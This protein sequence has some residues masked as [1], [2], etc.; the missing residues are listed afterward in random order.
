MIELSFEKNDN[1]M[2]V[3]VFEP[4]FTNL[5]FASFRE[6]FEQKFSESLFFAIDLTAVDY[7]DSAGIGSIITVNNNLEDFAKKHNKDFKI[8]LFGANKTVSNLLSILKIS[9]VMP[10][11]ET[12]EEAIKLFN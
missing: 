2:L 9:T 12:K 5:H 4:K 6:Q 11:C 3:K 1:F 10:V 8:V 7:I